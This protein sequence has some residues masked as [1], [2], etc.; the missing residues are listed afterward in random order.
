MAKDFRATQIETTKIILSGGLGQNGLGGIIY[1]GSVATD[2]EGGVPASMLDNVGEDVT[3]FISG[4]AE[5]K[6]TGGIVLVGGDLMTSG[7]F[8]AQLGATINIDGGSSYP[9][10]NFFVKTGLGDAF[11]VFSSPADVD[12]SDPAVYVNSANQN[13]DFSVKTGPNNKNAIYVD[14]E[15]E[16][17]AFMSGGNNDG[18]TSPGVRN[19]SDVGVFFSGSINSRGGS[20]RGTSLFGGD[21]VHSGSVY[22]LENGTNENLKLVRNTALNQNAFIVFEATNGS[23][24]GQIYANSAN[25]FLQTQA[26]DMI[27]RAGTANLLRMNSS[28]ERIGIGNNVTPTHI[29]HVSGTQ[30][31]AFRVDSGLKSNLINAKDNTV[32]FLSGGDP[33]SF[34]EASGNDVGFYVSGSRGGTNRSNKGIALFG[35]D[36]VVSGGMVTQTSVY[37]STNTK[38]SNFNVIP[39]DHFLFI[40]SSAGHVTASLQAASQ[41]G[42]GREL[43]FKDIAGY[44]DVNNIVLRPDGSDN[45]EGVNDDLT[46]TA[47]SGSIQLVCDGVSNYYVY[48]ERS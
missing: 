10:N 7:A 27:F 32:Y 25:M 29:L 37:R 18:I 15:R 2:R 11:A 39:S 26:G 20:F 12:T 43:I 42:V 13:I 41:A 21:V 44:S 23:N 3:L 28:L 1:S 40:D 6:G 14:A 35:G 46:M 30:F 47:I 19:M 4:T 17:I 16:Y 34:N 36:L 22:I 8:Y 24:I 5:G 38:T 31:A 33:S 9:N 48:G 45:I